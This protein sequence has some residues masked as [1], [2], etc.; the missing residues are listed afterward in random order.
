MAVEIITKEDLHHFRMQLLNDLKEWASDLKQ[1]SRGPLEGL[2]TKNVRQILNC[3]IGKLHILRNAGK[4]RWEKVGGTVYYRR[5]D[6][7]KLVEEGS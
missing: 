3:S 2:R 4:L 6:V 7:K 5:G 1:A